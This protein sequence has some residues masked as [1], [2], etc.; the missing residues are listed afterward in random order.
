MFHES[1]P[2]GQENREDEAT[3]M[4]SRSEKIFLHAAVKRIMRDAK[5][6]SQEAHSSGFTW[7]E[8]ASRE[9]IDRD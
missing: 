5:N 8:Q 4:P 9:M 1:T 3:R 7:G 6:Y 2:P